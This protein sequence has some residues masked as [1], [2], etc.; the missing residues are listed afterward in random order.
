MWTTMKYLLKAASATVI[1]LCTFSVSATNGYFAHG[2]GEANRALAGAGTAYGFDAISSLNNPA[3][4]L[5]IDDQ[6]QFELAIFSPKRGF[7][8]TGQ[9]APPPAFSLALGEVESGNE[10]FIIPG[11][12]WKTQLSED[13]SFNLAVYGNG[14]MNTEYESSVFYGSNAGVDLS[15]LFVN[16]GYAKQINTDLALGV[17]PIFAIQR[18]AATGL[19]A[20]G[21]FSSDASS[22]T[23]KG[24]EITTGFGLKLGM[25]Y[26][27]TDSLTIGSTYQSTIKMDKFSDYSG[28]FAEGGSF[29]IPSNFSLSSVYEWS[30]GSLFALDLQRINYSEVKSIANPLMPNIMQS[31]LGQSG[32]AGFG[33]QDIDVIKVGY[34]FQLADI[35]YRLG[36]S[37]GEQ[38]IPESEMLFNILAPGVQEIHYTAGIVV[39]D[40]SI[41]L[42]YSPKSKVAGPNP[43]T[44]DPVNGQCA[45]NINLYMSQVQLSFGY[46]F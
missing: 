15:Q 34:Q 46:R 24:H 17:A 39:D 1:T 35:T 18:F 42:M 29:D 19:E 3:S 37:H 20:F 41:S 43:L 10:Y 28:L 7:N 21:Q 26:Q 36:L 2:Y 40:L 12:G 25:T 8:V 5:Q 23:N 32:G 33:W 6:F 13:S 4:A 9:M 22:L 31:Q 16:F 14:G 44:C 30:N 11:F 45:Q 38:P 27:L